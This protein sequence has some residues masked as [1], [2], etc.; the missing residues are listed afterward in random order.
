M[1]KRIDIEKLVQWAVNDELPKGQSVTA[2][3]WDA[4]VP[5]SR[6]S[7]YTKGG[8]QMGDRS[9][10]YLDG[11]PHYDAI[12]IAQAIRK[13]DIT[14]GLSDEHVARK[15]LG[16]ELV[17]LDPNGVLAAMAVRPKLAAL[18]YNRAVLKMPPPLDLRLPQPKPVMRGTNQHPLVLRADP[19]GDLIEMGRAQWRAKEQGN[20]VGEPRCPIEWLDPTVELI[21]EQRAEYTL[22]WHALAN[23]AADLRNL[24]EHIAEAPH[25]DPMPWLKKCPFH[26]HFP[27]ASKNIVA[28]C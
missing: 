14:V 11:E 12:L 7:R 23:L 28:N 2:T 19:D 15:L 8:Y 3:G 1:K 21:A 6:I 4:I 5:T 22:W 16:P 26:A 10:V 25:K 13:L 20:L 24:T 17:T 27:T 9:D 18:V